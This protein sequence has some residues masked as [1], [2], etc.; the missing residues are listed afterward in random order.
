MTFFLVFEKKRK[1]KQ[2]MLNYRN[3]NFRWFI[4]FGIHVTLGQ[5]HLFKL[6]FTDGLLEKRFL[7][8]VEK[9]EKTKKK[10][11][12]ENWSSPLL[13][14]FMS[15]GKILLMKRLFSLAHCSLKNGKAWT[16]SQM[17]LACLSNTQ[18]NQIL[19]AFGNQV[20]F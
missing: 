13:C 4:F 2:Q 9:S 16:P 19:S 15:S 11:K 1:E 8:G 3:K 10:K 7:L 20:S 6:H 12:K 5:T 17:H 14:L 18:K